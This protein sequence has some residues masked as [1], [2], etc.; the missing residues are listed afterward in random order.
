MELLFSTDSKEETA[1][2][3]TTT[4]L[5]CSKPV[6]VHLTLRA[7]ADFDVGLLKKLKRNA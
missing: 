1:V 3:Y 4:Q 7:A 2:I 5:F 6:K